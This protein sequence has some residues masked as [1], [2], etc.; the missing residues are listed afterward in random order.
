MI[1]KGELLSPLDP[2]KKDIRLVL[3]LEMTNEMES[4]ENPSLPEQGSS[5]DVVPQQTSTPTTLFHSTQMDISTKT[6]V[7]KGSD[8]LLFSNRQGFLHIIDYGHELI[9]IDMAK[10]ALGYDPSCSKVAQL[11]HAGKQ[12]VY[13]QKVL[14]ESLAVLPYRYPTVE[15]LE[16]SEARVKTKQTLMK[17]DAEERA[18]TRKRPTTK[19][20][21]F[22]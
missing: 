19:G 2:R 10:T 8:E 7:G 6:D 18:K 9:R 14:H 13:A 17:R 16:A 12:I 3:D 15:D 1:E 21:L 5:N 20:E 4:P 22:S 11:T